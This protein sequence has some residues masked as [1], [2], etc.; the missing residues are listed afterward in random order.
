MNA[1]W[2]FRSLSSLRRPAGFAARGIVLLGAL[3][4]ITCNDVEGPD[5]VI[6]DPDTTG[7]DTTAVRDTIPPQIIT[8]AAFFLDESTYTPTLTWTAPFDDSLSEAVAGYEIRY[9]HS[10]SAV[11]HWDLGIPVFDPPDPREP[12]TRQECSTFDIVERGKNLYAAI[13]SIDEAD[14]MSARSNVAAVHIPGYTLRGTC[15]EAINGYPVFGLTVTVLNG[16]IFKLMTEADGTFEK[17]DL[18]RDLSLNITSG[19]SAIPYHEFQQ[20]IRLRDDSTHSVCMIPYTPTI[21]PD[22]HSLLLL[23][24][25]M[26]RTTLNDLSTTLRKW[27]RTPVACYIPPFVNAYGIDYGTIARQAAE[28][29]MNASGWMFF[30][31][32]DAPPDT[33][34]VFDFRTKDEMGRLVGITYHVD[35][36]DH[37]PLLDTVA[38]VDNITDAAFLYRVCLHELGHTIRFGHVSNQDFI[39]YGGQPLPNDISPDELSVLELFRGLP[40]NLDMNMYD[41]QPPG[42]E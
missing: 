18:T 16:Q 38:I 17:D 31:F 9:S 32:V 5:N 21:C 37:L 20:Q 12:G 25:I 34:I 8:D 15:F 22:Y 7:N 4:L 13:K 30:D 33:G 1:V 14:N 28:R 40:N 23:F 11:D 3:I 39:M 19:N 26:T 2:L 36:D 10:Y 24:K 6:E 42:A 41:D 35:G 29:W 27:K